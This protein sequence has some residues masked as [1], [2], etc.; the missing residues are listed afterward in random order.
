M[1]KKKFENKEQL[2][3]ELRDQI[4]T[5]V[6][7]SIAKKKKTSILLSGGSTPSGLFKKLSEIELDW[8][9]VNIGLVDDRMVDSDSEFSN[10]KLIQELFVS[11]TK[12]TTPQFFPLVFDHE[13]VKNNSKKVNEII[14]EIGIPDITI[15]GMGGDGHFASLFPT[16]KNS[17]RGLLLSNQ[18]KFCYTQAPS[19]P[20]QRISFTWPFLRKSAHLF[21]F[22]TGEEKL[23]LIENPSQRI[24]LPIEKL[25]NDRE[26]E[27]VLYWAP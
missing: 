10:S 25:M 7:E 2:E 8:S 11:K 18:N 13:H 6:K 4:I 5:L 24:D 15:L 1:I 9:Q 14:D 27:P 20:K 19:H 23:S 22:I 12:K 3:D 26:I 21:L 17:E 16:D